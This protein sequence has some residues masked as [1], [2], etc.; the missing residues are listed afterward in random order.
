MDLNE[1]LT[2]TCPL[3]TSSGGRFK[4]TCIFEKAENITIVF[5][6]AFSLYANLVLFSSTSNAQPFRYR[7]A[8]NLRQQLQWFTQL[9][10]LDDSVWSSFYSVFSSK[11]KKH[12]FFIGR[13]GNV[14]CT[15][16]IQAYLSGN[17]LTSL[18][19]LV[20]SSEDNWVEEGQ[21]RD[22]LFTVCTFYL[23][24]FVHT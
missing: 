8:H 17:I 3:F 7:E 21:E 13:F 18:L 23:L 14:K 20:T 12:L 24:N 6:C 10:E 15:F 5:H 22:L 4:F 2:Q 11:F 1:V 9:S 16:N 19:T